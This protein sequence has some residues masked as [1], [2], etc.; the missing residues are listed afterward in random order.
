MSKAVFDQTTFDASSFDG[1]LDYPISLTVNL[2]ALPSVSR[3]VAWDR[4]ITSNLSL[5]VTAIKGWGRTK[6]TTSNLSLLPSV[7]R[8]ATY[9]RA[10]VSALSVLVLTTVTLTV[11]SHLH[12]GELTQGSV[13]RIG[14]SIQGRREQ[15][16]ELAQGLARR[17]G[18]SVQG[19]TS[20]YD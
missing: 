15:L 4:G 19:R 7:T 13:R 5:A 6:A 17:I 10:T 9:T 14:E 1:I 8:A 18:E 2:S 16:G 12:L 3:A 20:K 11:M